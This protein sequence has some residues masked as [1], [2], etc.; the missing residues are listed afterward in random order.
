MVFNLIYSRKIIMLLKSERLRKVRP[1]VTNVINQTSTVLNAKMNSKTT[2]L[3]NE[4]NDVSQKQVKSKIEPV[5]F[6]KVHENPNKEK[7]KI[8]KLNYSIILF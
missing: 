2:T 1:S 7:I 5:I 6:F 4:P 3:L 8:G